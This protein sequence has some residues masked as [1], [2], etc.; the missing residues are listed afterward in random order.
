MKLRLAHYQDS[1]HVLG[2]YLRSIIWVQGCLKNCPG[3]I[4]E[5]SHDLNGREEDMSTIIKRIKAYPE[6]EGITI[7]GGEPFLQAQALC[8]L[9]QEVKKDN[10]GVIV[11]SG[12]TYQELKHM[13][14]PYVES[15]LSMI[16]LL[17]DGPYIQSLDMGEAGRGSS[18]Q[19]FIYLTDRYKDSTYYQQ[20]RQS[21]IYT[22]GHKYI[23]EGI[24]TT[25]VKLLFEAITGG[26]RQWKKT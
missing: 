12:Y 24:P 5:E 11:Y 1:S 15:L 26:K 14:D 6:N 21:V 19:N 22:D 16:D 9:V 17:I 8:E 7:S 10:K 18:N 25:E 4:A 2:P 23:L 20:E 3:C 13:N